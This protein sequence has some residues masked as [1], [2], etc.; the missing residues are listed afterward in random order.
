M[1]SA[2]VTLDICTFGDLPEQICFFLPAADETILV[3]LKRDDSLALCLDDG[4]TYQI[5]SDVPVSPQM[6]H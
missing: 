1:N 4:I 3:F 2:N 5:E 6:M